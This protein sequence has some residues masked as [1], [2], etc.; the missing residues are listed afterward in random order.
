MLA[1]FRSSEL[2]RYPSG[3]VPHKVKL[4]PVPAIRDHVHSGLL[5]SILRIAK[6]EFHEVDLD[7]DPRCVVA[8]LGQSGGLPAP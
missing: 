4:G 2:I 7:F 1:G 5:W 3:R 6:A 8:R